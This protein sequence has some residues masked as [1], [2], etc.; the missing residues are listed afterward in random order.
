[1]R[2]TSSGKLEMRTH[3]DLLHADRRIENGGHL[4]GAI[5]IISSDT[6]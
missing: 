1:M 5:N 4:T 3:S 2:H 6:L